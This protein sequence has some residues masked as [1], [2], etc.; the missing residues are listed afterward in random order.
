MK[1]LLIQKILKYSPNLLQA[2]V[3]AINSLVV[4]T[5]I[6]LN[7]YG[8]FA[9]YSALPYMLSSYYYSWLLI[10]DKNKIESLPS[11]NL[12]NQF[13][14]ISSVLLILFF[15][16]ATTLNPSYSFFWLSS[17]IL[18]I[19]FILSLKSN[20]LVN[21][22]CSARFHV[23]EVFLFSEFGGLLSSTIA[24]SLFYVCLKLSWVSDSFVLLIPT[25]NLLISCFGSICVLKFIDIDAL[26]S[27]LSFNFAF[28]SY[29]L[30]RRNTIKSF[31]SFLNAIHFNNLRRL[32]D[33][34]L[35][36]I[37]EDFTT[38]L[39]PLVALA[40]FGSTSAGSLRIIIS[41]VKGA[42][43]LFPQRYDLF[44]LS[45]SQIC[46]NSL[47]RDFKNF[48][49]RY[50]SFLL[51][52]F[53]I[54]FVYSYFNPTSFIANY[55]SVIFPP[56]VYFLQLAIILLVPF[57]AFSLVVSPALT[58][59]TKHY[60]IAVIASFLVNYSIWIIFRSQHAALISFCIT[61]LFIFSYSS[62]LVLSR[63]LTKD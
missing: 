43:K 32:I 1:E 53:S 49:I 31:K 59:N 12:I 27:K 41:F 19:F 9:S 6:G 38:T 35:F 17:S 13:N 20:S 10:R 36:K 24:M 47:F 60:S 23:R 58:L 28:S 14:F 50:Y 61:N 44:I 62:S 29:Y 54:L 3:M 42:S 57:L 51:A 8:V 52:S 26:E 11:V 22:Q 39:L 30:Y 16:I 55:F 5:L 21:S 40:S 56:E 45:L 2:A 37:Y 33:T 4:P 63:K 25:I 18:A 7:N 48:A 15:S 34:A 46:I